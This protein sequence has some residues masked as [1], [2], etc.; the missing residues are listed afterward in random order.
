MSAH[1]SEFVIVYAK[2]R[3]GRGKHEGSY[4]LAVKIQCWG[5]GWVN[6]SVWNT[7]VNLPEGD[8]ETRA[9]GI[10]AGLIFE[11][12][13]TLYVQHKGFRCLLTCV[14]DSRGKTPIGGQHAV[15]LLAW[16]LE[17]TLGVVSML[18]MLLLTRG[19]GSKR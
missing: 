4:W 12:E 1:D 16:Q 9:S 14:Q 3:F 6:R 8:V 18:A 13:L 2:D 11:V 17:L 7:P 10:I 5:T 15:D 19:S